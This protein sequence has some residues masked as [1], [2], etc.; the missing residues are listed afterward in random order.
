MCVCGGGAEGPEG[1]VCV[2]VLMG[3]GGARPA[4]AGGSSLGA[5]LACAGGGEGTLTLAL[6]QGDPEAQEAPLIGLGDDEDGDT[7]IAQPERTLGES[8]LRKQRL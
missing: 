7:G 1:R 3:R 4:F 8:A 6:A 5:G 2:G